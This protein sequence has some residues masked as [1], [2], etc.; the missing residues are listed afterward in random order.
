MKNAFARGIAR[1]KSYLI[2][3][4]KK[5]IRGCRN[6]EFTC[7]KCLGTQL[8]SRGKSR[9]YE[10]EDENNRKKGRRRRKQRT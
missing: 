1:E 8:L 9:L 6:S 5:L 7:N 2:E 4:I 3:V 10:T